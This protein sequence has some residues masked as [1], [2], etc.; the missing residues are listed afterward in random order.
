MLRFYVY[1]YRHAVFMAP[2]HRR[3]AGLSVIA[4]ATDT[5]TTQVVSIMHRS[6][7]STVVRSYGN[8][9]RPASHTSCLSFDSTTYVAT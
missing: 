2:S 3:F 5:P 6:E 8:S 4:G 7:S 1:R 9:Q